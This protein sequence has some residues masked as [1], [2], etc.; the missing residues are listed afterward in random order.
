M[1]SPVSISST[2]L[3]V[4]SKKYPFSIYSTINK[5]AFKILF[6]TFTK[7]IFEDTLEK[8]VKQTF[9]LLPNFSNC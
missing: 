7:E 2:A 9:C 3:P 1:P 6:K 8:I 5:P 4:Y